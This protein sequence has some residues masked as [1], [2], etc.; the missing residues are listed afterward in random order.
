MIEAP[1]VA[2]FLCEYLSEHPQVQ[3]LVEVDETDRSLCFNDVDAVSEIYFGFKN[4]NKSD[5]E[6]KKS[7][8]SDDKHLKRVKDNFKK[9]LAE[10]EKQGLLTKVQA[11][12]NFKRKATF[13]KYEVMDEH[14]WQLIQRKYFVKRSKLVVMQNFTENDE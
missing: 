2:D 6:N 14:L 9:I 11:G 8:D 7:N 10:K 1:F 4:G 12:T 3:Q 5:S 13:I